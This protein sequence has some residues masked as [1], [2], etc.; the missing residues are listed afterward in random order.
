MTKQVFCLLA[1]GFLALVYCSGAQLPR[2]IGVKNG[3]P[4]GD[5]G[6]VR[7]CPNTTRAVAFSIKLEEKT[8]LDNTALNGIR[9]YCSS[10]SENS[11]ETVIESNTQK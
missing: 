5:W 2:P 8:W 9:L 10:S 6:P 1:L 3:G 7:I 11:T 4:F